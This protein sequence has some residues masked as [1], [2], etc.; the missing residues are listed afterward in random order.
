M[1]LATSS[2]AKLVRGRALGADHTINYRRHPQGGEKAWELTGGRGVDHVIELGGPGTLAQSID[3]MRVG[4]HVAL[5][6]V[7]TGHGGEEPTGAMM[8]K[9]AR[10]YGLI[11]GNQE[12][13][14]APE[15]TGIHQVLDRTFAFKQL[16]DAFRYWRSSAHFGKICAEW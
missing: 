3:A 2:D 14:T 10:L 1:I 13:V 15:Q 12:F 5:I 7:L 9:Q 16:T 6:G 11:V 4:G 8:V